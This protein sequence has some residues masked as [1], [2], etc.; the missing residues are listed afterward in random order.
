[1]NRTWKLKL[2]LSIS[3]GVHLFVFSFLSILFPNFKITQLPILN[4]EVS[5]LPLVREEGE[6]WNAA[7]NGFKPYPTGVQSKE[8]EPLKIVEEKVAETRAES[9]VKTHEERKISKVDKVEVTFPQK[10]REPELISTP[11]FQSQVRIIYFNDSKLFPLENEKREIGSEREEKVVIASIGNPVSPTGSSEKPR[12]AMKSPSISGSEIIFD[13]PRYSENP[14]PVY[15]REARRKGYEG[16][17]LLR[18]EVLSNGRGGEI[19]VRGS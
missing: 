5:L 17:V 3:L 18:V 11:S 8:E 16:E 6:V 1:M 4:I 15:P 9:P 12:E 2:F 14:K 19:E 7:G 13:Q 10:E